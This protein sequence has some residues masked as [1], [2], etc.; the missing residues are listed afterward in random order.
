MVPSNLCQSEFMPA[1]DTRVHKLIAGNELTG[2][3]E[4]KTA[5]SP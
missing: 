4:Q 1:G 2:V 5:A 3:A